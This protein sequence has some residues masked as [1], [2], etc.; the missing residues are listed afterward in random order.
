[1]PWQVVGIDLDG[2]HQRFSISCPTRERAEQI[3]TEIEAGKF[4]G[5]IPSQPCEIIIMD[6]RPQAQ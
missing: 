4:K 5:K 3:K 2:R 6:Q 1:M